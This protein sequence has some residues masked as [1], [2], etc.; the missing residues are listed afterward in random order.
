M[1]RKWN[2]ARTLLLA[3]GVLFL[4]AA[5]FVTF[6]VR[7]DRVAD[8]LKLKGELSLV[9]TVHDGGKPLMNQVLYYNPDTKKAAIFDIPVEVGTLIASLKRMDSLDVLFRPEDPEE[10]LKKI[11]ELTGRNTFFYLIMDLDDVQRLVDLLGGVDVFISDTYENVDTNPM[12]LLPSGTA[13]LDGEKA[14]MFVSLSEEDEA[15]TDRIGRNQKFT[16]SLFRKMG[17]SVEYLQNPSVFSLFQTMLSSNMEERGLRTW[18]S[19]LSSMDLERLVFQRVMGARRLVDG[20]TL[21]FPHYNGNLLKEAVKQTWDSLKTGDIV[22]LG[23]GVKIEVLNGTTQAGLAGKGV[24]LFKGFGYDV[25]PG[26]N[27]DRTNVEV[28]EVIVRRGDMDLG[29]KVAQ[30]IKSTNIM[31]LEDPNSSVDVTIILGKDF[32]GRYVRSDNQSN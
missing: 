27:A 31:R 23:S 8:E 29:M 26:R 6:Q 10:Y 20:K 16:Q 15:E 22:G 32:D 18:V 5:V 30:H 2:A 25:L 17:D 3:M 4:A 14:Q 11:S 12:V 9:L 24:S 28:T 7:T 21:L 1:T 13:V 19:E